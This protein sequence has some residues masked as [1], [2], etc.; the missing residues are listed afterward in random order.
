SISVSPR[1]P[2]STS[3]PP[4]ISPAVAVSPIAAR[5][6]D[7]PLKF[8]GSRPWLLP[9]LCASQ[10]PGR[11]PLRVSVRPRDRPLHGSGEVLTEGRLSLPGEPEL[12]D[13]SEKRG[14]VDRHMPVR[15]DTGQTALGSGQGF[16]DG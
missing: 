11:P 9:C 14:V 1:L 12:G 8:L 5:L 4:T 6:S 7:C 15:V 10:G 3:S 13:S 16:R 2:P